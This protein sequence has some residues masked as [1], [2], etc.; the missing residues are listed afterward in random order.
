M[1]VPRSAT[2]SAPPSRSVTGAQKKK[3]TKKKKKKEGCDGKSK[4]PNVENILANMCCRRKFSVMFQ[5]QDRT[6]AAASR[7]KQEAHAD[8]WEHLVTSLGRIQTQGKRGRYGGG[9]H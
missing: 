8:I 7:S 3:V 6:V 5:R 1:K 4:R 9:A 2:H